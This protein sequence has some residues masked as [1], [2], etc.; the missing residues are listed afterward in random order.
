MIGPDGAGDT[1]GMIDAVC[2][3]FYRGLAVA[4]Q[5]GLQTHE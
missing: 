3:G 2:R 4:V 1:G 5:V